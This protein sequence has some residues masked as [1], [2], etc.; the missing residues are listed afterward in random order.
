MKSSK[1]SRE[2]VAARASPV[3]VGA[4]LVLLLACSSASSAGGGA[5]AA[6]QGGTGGDDATGTGA[7]SGGALVV[8]GTS[9]GGAPCNSGQL[10]AD[11]D[12][13]AAPADCDDCKVSVNPAAFDV[14]GNGVDEDCSGIPDDTPATCD[15]AIAELDD[16][17][18]MNAARAI[19]LCRISDGTTWGVL[20]AKYVKADGAPLLAGIGHG[21]LDDFGPAVKVREGARLLAL[22]SGSAR[23]PVDAGFESPSGSIHK[24]TQGFP[25][26]SAMPPGFPYD[27]P[28][29]PNASACSADPGSC[30]AN[31]PAAL[32]VKIKVPSNANSLKFQF[33][34][35]TYEFPMYIC[36][37]FNDFFV[38]LQDPAPPNAIKGN[39]S[40]DAQ[41]NPVSV[42]NGFLEV[43]SAQQ[44]GGKDFPCALGPGQLAGTGFDEAYASGPHASTGWLETKSPVKPSGIV[45]LRFAV[46][47][48]ADHVLDSTVLID[49]FEFSVEEAT[50]SSTSPVPVP[51]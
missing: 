28:A 49:A 16:D 26:E 20:E 15:G 43:C 19:G 36:S 32:E 35:F 50:G 27:P 47:D 44:A 24:D 9:G 41:G 51:K 38:V 21:L 12:G 31:D 40:F 48:V 25:E 29:C 18:A 10:D 39:I 46:W 2:W 30:T 23:R 5:G 42:N 34:F 13:Y 3:V 7:S 33:S 11:G 8:G 4:G 6:G 45:T 17:D 1:S 37:A 14:A 22:S